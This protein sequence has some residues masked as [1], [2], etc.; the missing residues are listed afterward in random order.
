MRAMARLYRYGRNPSEIME[1]LAEKQAAMRSAFTK[2]GRNDPCP[3][4][5]RMKFKQCHGKT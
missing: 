3:C 4:G 2:A 1:I 5:S